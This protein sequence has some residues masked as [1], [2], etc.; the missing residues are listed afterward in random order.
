MFLS[1]NFGATHIKVVEFQLLLCVHY[2]LLFPFLW[3][4]FCFG[5]MHQKGYKTFIN[6]VGALLV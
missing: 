1:F 3:H 4:G 5:A 2:S 6:S